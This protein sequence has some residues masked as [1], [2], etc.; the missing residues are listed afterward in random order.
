MLTN[1]NVT[2]AYG[3]WCRRWFRWTW[4][5]RRWFSGS[6]YPSERVRAAVE[7]AG[8]LSAASCHRWS[9]IGGANPPGKTGPAAPCCEW[10]SEP[11]SPGTG[12]YTNRENQRHV[13]LE[14]I[15][16][17]DLS[18]TLCLQ[19]WQACLS[20]QGI[21]HIMLIMSWKYIIPVYNEF[22]NNI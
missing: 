12:N 18:L 6:W 10:L 21:K 3:D 7:T 16:L 13:L 5:T 8:R 20:N 4:Y 15:T 22:A 14:I 11:R 2:R 9:L 19:K 1:V 17:I